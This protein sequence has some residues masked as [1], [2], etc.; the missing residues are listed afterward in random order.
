MCFSVSVVSVFDFKILNEINN[1]YLQPHGHISVP[2]TSSVYPV[3][4]VLTCTDYKL[5]FK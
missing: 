2:N 4:T 5:L 3:A 1:S